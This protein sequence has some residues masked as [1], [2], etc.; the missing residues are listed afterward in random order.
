MIFTVVLDDTV[1]S[2]GCNSVVAF[3]KNHFF[4][5]DFVILNLSRQ[6][7]IYFLITLQRIKNQ[8]INQGHFDDRK[9]ANA[10]IVHK[11][12]ILNLPVG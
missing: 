9:Y 11:S 1:L 5:S 6:L 4:L 12:K 10:F 7:S 3:F 8:V 2:S